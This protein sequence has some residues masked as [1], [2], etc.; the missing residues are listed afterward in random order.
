MKQTQTSV[1]AYQTASVYGNV[2]DANPH[3]LIQLLM[4]GVEQRIAKAQHA[5]ERGVVTEKC[6]AISSAISIIDGLAASLDM[7]VGGEISQNLDDL[8]AYMKRRLM[9]ANRHNDLQALKE[10]KSLISEIKTAW[11]ALPTVV[12]SNHSAGKETSSLAVQQA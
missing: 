1:N 2:E 6:E 8:Y 4:E 9:E 3:R 10:V 5:I 12:N 11:D 7:E